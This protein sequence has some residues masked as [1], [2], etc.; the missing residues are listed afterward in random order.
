MIALAEA[1]SLIKPQNGWF[2]PNCDKVTN[3][4]TD[5]FANERRKVRVKQVDGDSKVNALQVVQRSSRCCGLLSF[6]STLHSC[7]SRP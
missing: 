4:L 7:L 6:L 5:Q 1:M 2:I 3:F